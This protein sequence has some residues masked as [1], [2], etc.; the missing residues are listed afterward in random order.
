MEK[1]VQQVAVQIFKTKQDAERAVVEM[2]RA[3]GFASADYYSC[4]RNLVVTDCRQYS[5]RPTYY[6]EGMNPVWVAIGHR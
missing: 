4:A 2:V 6:D 1:K 5:P 3:Q